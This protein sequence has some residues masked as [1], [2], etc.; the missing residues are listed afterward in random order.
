[1]KKKSFILIALAIVLAACNANEPNKTNNDNS[2]SSMVY[3][4]IF[5]GKSPY[6]DWLYTDMESFVSYTVKSYPQDTIGHTYSKV[7]RAE[8]NTLTLS[9]DKKIRIHDEYF[10]K[11]E[12]DKT[13]IQLTRTANLVGK[14]NKVP[15]RKTVLGKQGSMASE[16]APITHTYV[17]EIRTAQPIELIRPEIDLCNVMPLCYYENFEIE[18]NEDYDNP[19]GVVIIAQW[20]GPTIYGPAQ[21]TSVTNVDIV[22][23]TGIAVL[24]T[25]LFEG[26][27]DE[28]LVSLWL[29]RGN[30]LTIIED[31]IP[32]SIED[33]AQESP[34]VLEELLA[35]N[36]ELLIQLQPFMFG[37][38]A[39]ASFSFFLIRNL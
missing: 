7:T 19:N 9:E 21:N 28:A 2:I 22:E 32:V 11:E 8:D 14:D 16:G 4:V 34:E 6:L 13:T 1:M 38:G 37:T 30:L 39:V 15:Q 24:N 29:I 25:D 20:N 27:P 26:M 17:Y 33:L 23:D 31:E 5:K 18:W 10:F 3:N 35:N 12:G 36:P